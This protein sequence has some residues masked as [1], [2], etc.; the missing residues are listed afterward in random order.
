MHLQSQYLFSGFELELYLSHEFAYVYFELEYIL[1]YIS[2][3][4]QKAIDIEEA[5]TRYE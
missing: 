1:N 2:L 5:N 4:F 3:M